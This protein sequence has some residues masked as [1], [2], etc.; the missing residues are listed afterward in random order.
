MARPYASEGVG[1]EAAGNQVYVTRRTQIQRV[2]TQMLAR[3]RCWLPFP[4]R[5]THT[6]S[7][8]PPTRKYGPRAPSPLWEGA[9]SCS[10]ID[11]RFALMLLYMSD[12][13]V[14][15]RRIS[16]KMSTV[17]WKTGRR[18]SKNVPFSSV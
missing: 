4:K 6:H 13:Q 8:E 12:K 17:R 14:D 15:I 18:K 9:E 7:I 2:K 10:G 11:T 16:R 3:V 1:G 5:R